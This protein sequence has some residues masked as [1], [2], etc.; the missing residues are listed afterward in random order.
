MVW[1]FYLDHPRILMADTR[2][3]KLKHAPFCERDCDC[4]TPLNL[5][6]C[7]LT[8]PAIGVEVQW[9]FPAVNIFDFHL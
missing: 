4:V 6:R 3:T 2:L 8:A 9:N 5:G 1:Q 7:Q